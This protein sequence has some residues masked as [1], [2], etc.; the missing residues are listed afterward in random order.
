MIFVCQGNCSIFKVLC[1]RNG[2]RGIMAGSL[3]QA[4]VSISCPA[5]TL[6][7][8][9]PFGTSSALPF[10]LDSNYYST[11]ISICK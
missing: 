6:R 10:S 9:F 5:L 3:F 8:W 4:S 1:K 7:S 11:T 2:A